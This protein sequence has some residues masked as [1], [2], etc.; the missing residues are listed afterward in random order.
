MRLTHF[1]NDHTEVVRGRTSAYQPRTNGGWA[2]SIPAFDNEGAT[3]LFTT[4]GGR[5]KWEQNF[6]S[7]RHAA[8]DAHAQSGGDC[9]G[10]RGVRATLTP[11]RK[12]GQFRPDRSNPIS[13]SW[14]YLRMRYLRQKRRGASQSARRSHSRPG[15]E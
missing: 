14:T 4:V 2:I 11:T 8:V 3:S 12:G 13:V 7:Q 1:H 10:T 9:F 6:V 15:L 5:L